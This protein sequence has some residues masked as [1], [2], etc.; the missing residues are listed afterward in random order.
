[1]SAFD[2][3]VVGDHDWYRLQLT[4]GQKINIA[5]NVLT[6]EDSY[7]YIRNAGGTIL[8]ENDDGGGGRGSRLV[9]TAPTTGRLC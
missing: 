9:F 6:L 8:G 3:E 2:L 4:A 7:V 5:V 1:M